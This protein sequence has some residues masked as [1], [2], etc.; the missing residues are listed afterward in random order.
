[1]LDNNRW[2]ANRPD[3]YKDIYDEESYKNSL[4]YHKLTFRNSILSDSFSLIVVVTLIATGLFG[5]LDQYLNELFSPGIPAAL[6]FFAVISIGSFLLNLPFEIYQTFSIEER[7]GFNK[8]TPGLFISDCLKT[9]VIA[10]I[11]GG[12]LISGFVYLY[13]TAGST[14]CV[15][16]WLSI[17]ILMLVG[18]LI[19][20]PLILPL[21]N[22]LEKLPEGDL[23]FAI[24][25]YCHQ[26]NFPVH[27][28][29][30][31]DGSKRST[32]A[33]AFL[34]GIGPKKKI[35]LF[36]TLISSHNND[37]IVAVLA[38]EVGHNKHH[39]V[40]KGL[41]QGMLQLAFVIWLFAWFIDN[42]T[43]GMILGSEINTI[44]LA[45]FAFGIVYSPFSLIVG[46]LFNYFSR[47]HEY[48]ADMY[49]ALTSYGTELKSALLKLSSK[50]FS[51]PDPH[52]LSVFFK[53]SHPTTLQ[54]IRRIDK[55]LDT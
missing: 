45:L 5:K 42:Q 39:H 18:N 11:L 29:Y 54:R 33:N 34:S 38:H 48:E 13:E 27:D 21:F 2:K 46:A 55:A 17:G 28:I 23:K 31:M 51:N 3:Q 15:Y 20:V 43:V 10:S 26:N 30:I 36:D 53:Y 35:V 40:S 44:E 6:S 22:K 25:N 41:F 7:F 49:A 9:T 14:F 24:K 47:K 8:V 52:P 37:E 16:T 12:I 19:Y 50:N 4:K 32:K 1:M